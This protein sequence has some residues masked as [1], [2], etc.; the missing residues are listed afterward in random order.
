MGWGAGEGLHRR[1]RLAPT[2]I[3]KVTPAILRGP[4]AGAAGLTFGG[5][6]G[7]AAVALVQGPQ[8]LQGN[9]AALQ[10]ALVNMAVVVRSHRLARGRPAVLLHLAVSRLAGGAGGGGQRAREE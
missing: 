7:G 8:T 1:L 6:G 9:V 2:S 4:L 10:D 3:N 5:G